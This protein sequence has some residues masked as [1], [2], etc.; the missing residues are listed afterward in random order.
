MSKFFW[1]KCNFVFLTIFSVS[2]LFALFGPVRAAT[3]DEIKVLISDL[4]QQ[5]EDYKKKILGLEAE[6]TSLE[7]QAAENEIAEIKSKEESQDWCHD[8][9][10]YLRYGFKG[11]EV[12]ALQVVL[13]KEG[14]NIGNEKGNLPKDSYYGRLTEK[15]VVGFQENYSEDILDPLGYRFGTGKAGEMTLGKLN[16]LYGC[17][18]ITEKQEAM[19]EAESVAD[20][21]EEEAEDEEESSWQ[22]IGDQGACSDSDGG[23]NYYAKGYA[24]LNDGEEIWD[25]CRY[26]YVEDSR[27]DMLY[28]VYCEGNQIKT[29]EHQCLQ[30]CRESA[31]LE[32]RK[33][34]LVMSSST[35]NFIPENPRTTEKLA[36]SILIKNLGNIDSAEGDLA[37][38]L[39]EKENAEFFEATTTVGKAIEP[40]GEFEFFYSVNKAFQESGVY[41]LIITLNSDNAMPEENDNN[42]TL[43]KTFSV[44]KKMT[45]FDSDEA[46]AVYA[47]GY[48]TIDEGKN[49]VWDSCLYDKK[50]RIY[51]LKEAYC[52]GEEKEGQEVFL[53][54]DG[55]RDGVCLRKS[56]VAYY[57]FNEGSGN[58]VR[59]S[60]SNNNSGEGQNIAWA[61]G[62][63]GKALKLEGEGYV[64][65]PDSDSLDLN[66][67][68]TVEFWVKYEGSGPGAVVSKCKSFNS[69]GGCNYASF[70]NDLNFQSAS[71][72]SGNGNAGPSDGALLSSG[73]ILEDIW[74]HVATA[75]DGKYIKLYVNSELK[76]T[77][78][79]T[80]ANP[81]GINE[82][83]LLIG[84]MNC[85][86]QADCFKFKGMIDELKIYNYARSF[87]KIKSDYEE[88]K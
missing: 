73:S 81:P 20:S 10:A 87:E 23:K 85:N 18:A 32:D 75:F 71:F 88:S 65:I 35:L 33:A 21:K 12:N 41:K 34:D 66:Y 46:K 48:S 62:V 63:E 61:D 52:A 22:D 68:G 58:I 67:A 55:C 31:C 27:I 17:A 39:I 64:T 7:K 60:S 59:D 38:I 44:A 3:N 16:E 74:Y 15:A 72:R 14:F 37:K 2:F 29:N 83:V 40:D 78:L 6:I 5:I 1:K 13:K 77:V 69:Y 86:S 36:L 26:F 79:Q 57:K 70:L 76:K 24:L 50:E 28:E 19:K 80:N 45:C 49:K 9:S 82:A 25:S 11:E 8:F 42:N 53:C 84:A 43:E 4:K 30:G 56:L 47:K 51:K 54:S